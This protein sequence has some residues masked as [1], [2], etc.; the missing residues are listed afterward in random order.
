MHALCYPLPLCTLAS[1]AV[2][3]V[4]GHRTALGCSPSVHF[5]RRLLLPYTYSCDSKV[6]D[7]S[8][9][10][11]QSKIQLYFHCTRTPLPTIAPW[12][13]SHW[14]CGSSCGKSSPWAAAATFCQ[15]RPHGQG[16]AGKAAA[17]RLGAGPPC[18]AAAAIVVHKMA[19]EPCARGWALY[20]YLM[21]THSNT[22]W[23]TALKTSVCYQ[24]T[25]YNHQQ[26]HRLQLHCAID[27]TAKHRN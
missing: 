19:T 1:D 21:P 27:I 14:G 26:K 15:S 17:S 13:H 4:R 8:S 7:P 23:Q 2:C 16:S 10:S 24:S 20:V 11:T 12:V 18:S 5:R 6:T 3:T 22:N 9:S 25:K